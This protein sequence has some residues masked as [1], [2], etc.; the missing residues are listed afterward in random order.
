MNR[1]VFLDRDGVLNE[2]LIGYPHKI[3]H[4]KPVRNAAEA[5]KLLGSM[6]FLKIM[7]TNQAGVGEG[8]FKEKDFYAFNDALLEKVG[9]V[10]DVFACFHSRDDG[11]KCRKP[12]GKMLEDA[13]KKH[14]LDL[15]KSYMVGDQDRDIK[16]GRSV[17]CITI[18]V[19][20][21]AYGT[22]ESKGNNADYIASDLL[23]AARWIAENEN[24]KSE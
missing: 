5:M 7:V 19:K 17:G 22:S 18:F 6:G 20:S 15:R 11:C 9:K 24:K 3:E 16:M 23:D 2:D 8:Y 1:A 14:K 10:D 4:L 12:S 13:A 21:G